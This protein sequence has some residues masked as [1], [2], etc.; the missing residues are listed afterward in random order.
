[1][2]SSGN[3]WS[4]SNNMQDK[5]N[6]NHLEMRNNRET[7]FSTPK[8]SSMGFI[9]RE[10]A[11]Q[12]PASAF[13]HRN[14]SAMNSP[15]QGTPSRIQEHDHNAPNFHVCKTEDLPGLRPD[16]TIDHV[17]SRIRDAYAVKG[18]KNWEAKFEA[19][20]AL[21]VINK[22]FPDDIFDVFMH[23][24]DEIIASLALKSPLIHRSIMVFIYEVYTAKRTKYLDDRITEKLIPILCGRANS[25]SKS[26]RDIS[27]SCLEV[28][29]SKHISNISLYK[30]AETAMSIDY[31]TAE[32]GMSML[33]LSM[34]TLG[35]Q[36]TEIS[37]NTLQAIFI[38]F[39]RNLIGKGARMV[40]WAREGADF[41]FRLMGEQNFIR[42][43]TQL[44]DLGHISSSEGNCIVEIIKGGEKMRPKEKSLFARTEFKRDVRRTMKNHRIDPS[45]IEVVADQLT[46]N[47]ERTGEPYRYPDTQGGFQN[48]FFNQ[49][50]SFRRD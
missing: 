15:Y 32:K 31:R 35:A 17:V 27:K 14:E 25:S 49:Q 47:R 22:A 21:R 41:M 10:E 16:I 28:I 44:H 45:K 6:Y 37:E 40:K 1:M 19:V 9:S 23:F 4:F 13:G 46:H 39:A 7:S 5:E 18:N 24:G 33:G 12:T 8:K 38:A 42:L 2:Y 48:G 30:F 29:I 43:I 34:G 3:Q 20:T 50:N 36:I 26:I 11:F